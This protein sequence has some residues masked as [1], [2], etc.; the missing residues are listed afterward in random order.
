MVGYS[1]VETRPSGVVKEG[2]VSDL[3][4]GRHK[5]IESAP[6]TISATSAGIFS[7]RHECQSSAFNVRASAA[8]D[9]KPARCAKAIVGAKP[10]HDTRLGS[11]KTAEMA[12]EICET[13]IQ[14]TLFCFDEHDSPQAAFSVP[15]WGESRCVSMP[16]ILSA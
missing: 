14:R 11:S 6:A 5:T 9:A 12:G 8:K 7:A 1:F 10:A 16:F 3:C 13:R 2:H 15:R 4:R